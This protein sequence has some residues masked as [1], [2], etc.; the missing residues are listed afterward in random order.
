[1]IGHPVMTNLYQAHGFYFRFT[2]WKYFNVDNL[3]PSQSCG[4][5]AS[6]HAPKKEGAK[7]ARFELSFYLNSDSQKKKSIYW[8]QGCGERARPLPFRAR[9]SPGLRHAPL[10]HPPAFARTRGSTTLVRTP[11][12]SRAAFFWVAPRPAPSRLARV[13]SNLCAH[14][15]T[16]RW[17]CNPSRSP[18]GLHRPSFRVPPLCAPPPAP[19]AP[20]AYTQRGVCGS[21]QGGGASRISDGRRGRGRGGG[22]VVPLCTALREGESGVRALVVVARAE[23]VGDACGVVLARA[24]RIGGPCGVV[25]AQAEGVGSA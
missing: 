17:R 10:A 12:R 16:R 2:G 7:K 14:A 13:S 23:H 20:T 4:F 15:R 25:I 6:S 18:L 21:R 24:E 8:A 1:M 5:S 9:P 11:L 19:P 22:R 3:S